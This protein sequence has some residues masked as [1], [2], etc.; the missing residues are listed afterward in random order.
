MNEIKGL[1]W[2]LRHCTNVKEYNDVFDKID[3]LYNVFMLE[4]RDFSEIEHIINESES[5]LPFLMKQLARPSIL[6]SDLNEIL[7]TNNIKT[8]K[9]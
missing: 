6:W 8:L 4:G 9:A 5:K 1:A 7:L 3:E 2:G